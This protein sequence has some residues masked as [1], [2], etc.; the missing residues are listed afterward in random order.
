MRG[1]GAQMSWQAPE[2]GRSATRRNARAR[3]GGK[4]YPHRDYTPEILAFL[5]EIHGNIRRNPSGD[6]YYGDVSTISLHF[7]MGS[8]LPAKEV[9]W[10]WYDYFD[11]EHSESIYQT[12]RPLQDEA[13]LDVLSRC[14]FDW[15]EQ[16]VRESGLLFL[17]RH[18]DTVYAKIE[19]FMSQRLDAY[20]YM[21]DEDLRTVLTP[22]NTRSETHVRRLLRQIQTRAFTPEQRAEV[23]GC[24]GSAYVNATARQL[25]DEALTERFWKAPPM[26][27]EALKTRFGGFVRAMVEEARRLGVYVSQESF[28]WSAWSRARGGTRRGGARARANGTAGN[29]SDGRRQDIEAVH[30]AILGLQPSATL[31]EVKTAYREKAK[32]YH[33]DQGGT[34]R[35]FLQVQ[36]AYEYL[37]SE[38]Y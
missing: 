17:Q 19:A 6:F 21:R 2:N 14:S 30:Y 26:E 23:Y 24:F 16:A 3:D 10:A 7:L 15:D 32:R 8:R 37:L 31:P 36:E 28:D 25:M 34:V 12:L 4:V 5:E 9:L 11:R 33:P 35:E 38:V 29:G 22:R 20:G 1:N 13:F 18:R 27:L